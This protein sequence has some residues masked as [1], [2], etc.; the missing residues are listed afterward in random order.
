MPTNPDSMLLEYTGVFATVGQIISAGFSNV[1]T[2]KIL[3]GKSNIE[4]AKAA[5][6][7]LYELLDDQI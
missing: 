4:A 1:Y 7:K 2:Q 3:E 6:P 5:I